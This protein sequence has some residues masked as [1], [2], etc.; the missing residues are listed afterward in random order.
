[1]LLHPCK[2]RTA[3]QQLLVLGCKPRLHYCSSN[4]CQ[5]QWVQAGAVAASAECTTAGRRPPARSITVAFPLHFP[6]ASRWPVQHWPSESGNETPGQQL[7][8]LQHIK[9]HVGCEHGTVNMGSPQ[10]APQHGNAAQRPTCQRSQSSR[11]HC[12]P[13][14][15]HSQMAHHIRCPATQPGTCTVDVGW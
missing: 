15:Q 2:N 11:Y 1:M 8:C 14:A 5:K 13:A 3:L 12:C 10:S 9:A 6:Q 7:P 4:A